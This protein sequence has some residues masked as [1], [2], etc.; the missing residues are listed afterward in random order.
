M[1]TADELFG[2]GLAEVGERPAVAA[3]APRRAPKEDPAYRCAPLQPGQP[4]TVTLPYP[5]SANR[6]WRTRVVFPKMEKMAATYKDGGVKA[7]YELLTRES[8]VNTYPSEH[9]KAFK[10]SVGWLLASAGV[11][12]P[13]KARRFQVDIQLWPH[14]PQDW[15]T[16]MRKDPLY[17]ADT[18][19]RLDLD[20][21]R[22]A[23]N[24]ALNE[25]VFAD[26]KAIWKDSGEVMEPDGRDAC[27]IVT[28][29]PLVKVSPQETLL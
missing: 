18:V 9:G 29:T 27:V 28:I 16:R 4:V 6:Y 21:T 24:D 3:P 10:E 23:I 11:R 12:E 22:K 8:F 15:K 5:P 2:T 26:D 14:R 1:S 20:N 13:M 25:R 7:L 19:Q 17:W